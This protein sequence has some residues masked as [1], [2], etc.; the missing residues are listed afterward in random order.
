M[1]WRLVVPLPSGCSSC[2]TLLKD[3]Q[4][5]KMLVT[6]SQQCN[7][8]EVLN[9]DYHCCEKLISCIFKRILFIFA[10][11]TQPH[12]LSV[13]IAM[14]LSSV[15]MLVNSVLLNLLFILSPSVKA[16]PSDS[17]V[18][19]ETRIGMCLHHLHYLLQEKFPYCMFCMYGIYLWH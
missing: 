16:V 19:L 14:D 11:K 3:L 7:I 13:R 15:S 2:L 4:S 1:I 8:P 5:L 9:V 6:S 12:L 17:T 10:I 18:L